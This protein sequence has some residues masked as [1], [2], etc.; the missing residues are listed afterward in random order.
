MKAFPAIGWKV[1]YVQRLDAM[2]P[3]ARR[4]ARVLLKREG[5]DT[6]VLPVRANHLRIHG[7]VMGPPST[8]FDLDQWLHCETRPDWVPGKVPIVKVSDPLTIEFVDPL[9]S[10]RRRRA[11][12]AEAIASALAI[13]GPG[14]LLDRVSDIEH[15]DRILDGSPVAVAALL[16]LRHRIGRPDSPEF[17]DPGLLRNR[18]IKAAPSGLDKL[19][20]E[21][22]KPGFDLIRENKAVNNSLL[23]AADS[24]FS[25]TDLLASGKW[26][27]VRITTLWRWWVRCKVAMT[28]MPLPRLAAEMKVSPKDLI[29]LARGEVPGQELLNHLPSAEAALEEITN[30]SKDPSDDQAVMSIVEVH[31]PRLDLMSAQMAE[32]ERRLN[33]TGRLVSWERLRERVQDV[34]TKVVLL[35]GAPP[36]ERAR[37]AAENVRRDILD[38]RMDDPIGLAGVIE[39]MATRLLGMSLPFEQ[40]LGEWSTELGA[41]VVGLSPALI[42]GDVGV[43]RF[44]IAHQIGH[45]I[46]SVA[47]GRSRPCTSVVVGGEFIGAVEPDPSEAFANA[48]AAYLIAPRD[49]VV[50]LVDRPTEMTPDWILGAV[51]DIARYFGLSAG[52]SL[53]HVL[54]CLRTQ[55]IK[56]NVRKVREDPRW[57]LHRAETRDDLENRWTEDR[58][59]VD[60]EVGDRLDDMDPLGR[61][62]SA[63]FDELVSRATDEGLLSMETCRELDAA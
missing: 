37:L 4:P 48:F 53:W 52:A 9:E 47:F 59:T 42:D 38:T 44:A 40:V 17:G 1:E 45:M 14:D 19:R 26:A 54:N 57:L 5:F 29:A 46:E 51:R 21:I 33:E 8:G 10:M 31:Q 43:L 30:L 50:G 34:A 39:K 63:A 6:W 24:V 32:L 11:E 12:A 28:R 7:H 41:P 25:S 36:W 58:R 56:E 27:H 23:I 2:Q 61:P 18:L 13:D 60:R 16:A 20:K 55:D 3:D 62:R 15:A 49:A 22:R 35:E